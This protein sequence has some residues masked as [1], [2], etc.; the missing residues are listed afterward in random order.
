MK[1]HGWDALCASGPIA[2]RLDHPIGVVG[3]G[4]QARGERPDL[5]AEFAYALQRRVDTGR[6]VS[7]R[8]GEH[9]DILDRRMDR[10]GIVGDDFLGVVQNRRGPDRECADIVE[11][12]RSCI[13]C[14][15]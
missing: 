1:G 11:N 5:L 12:L 3:Q 15:A 4:L 14:S 13:D 7:Q 10:R 8:L 6:V 9:I 2:R